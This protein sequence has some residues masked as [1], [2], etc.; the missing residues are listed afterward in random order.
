MINLQCNEWLTLCQIN[1]VEVKI[2]SER[3]G[4]KFILFF[5][6]FFILLDSCERRLQM[7]ELDIYHVG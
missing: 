7:I 1:L 6:F 4:K 2:S 3:S 5:P